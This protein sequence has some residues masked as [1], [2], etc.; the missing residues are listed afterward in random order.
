MEAHSSQEE[1]GQQTCDPVPTGTL[2]SAVPESWSP[3]QTV[4]SFFLLGLH[5]RY[6]EVPRLGVE[7]ELQPPAYTTATATR[8]PSLICNLHHSS[9]QRWI[10]NPLI[11]ARNQTCLLMDTSLVLNLLSYSGNSQIVF[12]KESHDYLPSYVFSLCVPSGGRS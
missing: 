7:S 3:R 1:D 10:F 2:A 5:P 8:D 11:K 9:R 6:M 12:S 4:F